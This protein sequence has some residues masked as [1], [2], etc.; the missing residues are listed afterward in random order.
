[1]ANADLDK[2]REELAAAENESEWLDEENLLLADELNALHAQYDRDVEQIKS[3]AALQSEHQSLLNK[4]SV[5]AKEAADREDKLREQIKLAD[6]E[7]CRLKEERPKE[8]EAEMAKLSAENEKSLLERNGELQRVKQR[9]A[10]E[11]DRV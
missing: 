11:S 6:E 4:L 1:M 2:L 10:D 7:L 8:I 9:Y 3:L 5:V